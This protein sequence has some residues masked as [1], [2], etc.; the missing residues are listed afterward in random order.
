MCYKDEYKIFNCVK[1]RDCETVRFVCQERI[2]RRVEKRL[3][4]PHQSR[5][6][7]SSCICKKEFG[8]SKFQL[9]AWMEDGGKAATLPE[10]DITIIN[11]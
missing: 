6:L 1:S 9:G 11:S 8:W 5:W 10:N 3:D 4:G 2:I 7:L